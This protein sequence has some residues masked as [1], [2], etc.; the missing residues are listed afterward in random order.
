M[1]RYLPFGLRTSPFFF[2]LFARALNWIMIAILG[3][4]FVLHYLDDFFAVLPPQANAEAYCRD[5]DLVCSQLG[6][7]VNHS[8]NIMGTKAEILGIEFDSLLMQARLPSDKLARARNTANDLLNRRIISRHEP[9]SAV[10][11]LLFAA[12]IVILGRAFVR[13]LLDAIRRPVIMIRIT[14]HI[15]ADLLWW[16]AFLKD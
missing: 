9:E 10:G 8:K 7:V 4:S 16:K 15:K 14:K 1:E 6:L 2:D 3:W 12:K 5:F 13:R 11:F